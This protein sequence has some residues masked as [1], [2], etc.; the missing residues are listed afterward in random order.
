MTGKEKMEL[1]E[2]KG[3]FAGESTEFVFSEKVKCGVW[4]GY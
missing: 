1:K 3:A 4:R 2:L